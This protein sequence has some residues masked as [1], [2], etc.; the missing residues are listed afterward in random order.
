MFLKINDFFASQENNTLF[1]ML[2]E[3]RTLSPFILKIAINVMCNI[4]HYFGK[5][6]VI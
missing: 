4:M 3:F 1:F 6:I 5:V 2:T